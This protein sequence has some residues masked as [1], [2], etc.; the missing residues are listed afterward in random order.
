MQYKHI[1]A[2]LFA[3]VLF[4][5]RLDLTIINVALPTVAQHFKVPI[6]V[7]DWL[8]I[9]F[10][11]ALAITIPISS[12]LGE[13]YG[14]KKVYS[15][16]I[17]LFGLGSLFCLWAPGLKVLILLRFMQ[18]LGGGLLIPLGMTLLYQAYD[19]ED[20]ANITSFVFL[21]ALIAPAIAP[22]L[23]GLLLE[24]FGWRMVFICSGPLALLVAVLT[25]FLLK[26]DSP[27]RPARLDGLGFLLAASLLAEVFYSLSLLARQG[28]S[29]KILFHSMVVSALMAS[30]IAWERRVKYPL[31]DLSLFTNTLFLKANLLQLC[32][33]ICH[34]GSIFLVGIY[35]QLGIGMSASDAGLIVGTQALGAMVTSR[36]SVKLF[37]R[38][39]AKRPI[40]MGLAGVAALS[41][42]ILF[43]HTP[44]ASLFGAGIFFLRGIFSGLCGA[45]I[46]ALS[47]IGFSKEK[48][49]Q[50]NSLFNACRQIAIS[51]G[52]AI[53]SVLLGL[54]LKILHLIHI[55]PID[56]LQVVK[57]F[58][59]AFGAIPFFA[60]LGIVIALGLSS[61]QKQ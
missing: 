55:E 17:L 47:V 21:S 16:A 38:H 1:V 40:V 60:F 26:T 49:A 56:K 3:I 52:V 44:N 10:L 25:I 54:S 59:L 39:G 41:P 37:E 9:A 36:Y 31:I 11:L 6:L 45:P 42:A 58:C 2:M 35:L 50:V 32:F 29:L 46:Q 8:S 28:F 48:L 5:D 53:S 30:F 18:G 61:R 57:I 7:T 23:G 43:I 22:L 20:Y 34:F 4:L 33:Q 15:I 13:R 19:K 12:W 27:T 24:H 14:L 51:L